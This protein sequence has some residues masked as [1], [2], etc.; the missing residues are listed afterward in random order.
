V[1]ADTDARALLGVL[2]DDPTRHFSTPELTSV[3]A[4]PTC[5]VDDAVADVTRS[6]LA[7]ANAGFV[8][9]SR[10]AIRAEELAG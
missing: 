4:W 7:H 5:R 6:G 9:A 3:L 1:D 10:A 8:W 2:L